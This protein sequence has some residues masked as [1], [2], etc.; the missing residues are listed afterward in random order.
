[1]NGAIGSAGHGRRGNGKD[2]I[3]AER[4]GC[5]CGRCSVGMLLV[6]E[7]EQKVHQQLIPYLYIM[8]LVFRMMTLH[9]HYSFPTHSLGVWYVTMVTSSIISTTILG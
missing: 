4:G 1:M 8:C 5:G 3:G 6:A 7:S 2:I 9:V